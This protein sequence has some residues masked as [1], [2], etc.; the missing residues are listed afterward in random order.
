MSTTIPKSIGRYRD[1]INADYGH[2]FAEW[3]GFDAPRY[4]VNYTREGAV[5]FRMVSSR[6]RGEW[7]SQKNFAKASYKIALANRIKW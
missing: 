4:E 2:S 7:K 5:E 1:F 6:A 3:L